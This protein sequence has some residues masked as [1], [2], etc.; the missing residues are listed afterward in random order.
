MTN[1]TEMSDLGSRG[2]FSRTR[3]GSSILSRVVLVVVLVITSFVIG[4][5]VTSRDVANLRALL[6]SVQAETQKAKQELASQIS[7]NTSV[8]ARLIRVTADFEAIQPQK[9]TYSVSPNQSIALAEGR[10]TVALVGPPGTNDLVLNVNGEQR[11]ASSGDIIQVSAGADT[12]RIAVQ[13]F[14]LFRALI[15]VNCE[16]AS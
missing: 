13:K 6:S 1:S 12:C 2:S 10:L 14:D 9:N 5:Y 4:V 7:V 3:R 8:Q 11:K 15:N 16:K